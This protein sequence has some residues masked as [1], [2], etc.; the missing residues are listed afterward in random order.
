MHSGGIYTVPA[1]KKLVLKS[2]G[3]TPSAPGQY[4]YFNGV[5]LNGD[6]EVVGVF[7][8]GSVFILDN[9]NLGLTGYLLEN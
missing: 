3:W 4:M 7:S 9:T 6:P 5:Q 2:N 1:E 8:S